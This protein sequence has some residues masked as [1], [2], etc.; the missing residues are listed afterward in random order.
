[1]HAFMERDWRHGM[2]FGEGYGRGGQ[3]FGHFGQQND[4]GDTEQG[5]GQGSQL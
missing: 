5:R 1:M 2:R 3:G 4:G